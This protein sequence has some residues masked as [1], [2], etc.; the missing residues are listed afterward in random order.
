MKTFFDFLKRRKENL[1]HGLLT[2]P[3]AYQDQLTSNFQ[4]ISE[5][6]LQME[7]R[8]DALNQRIIDID[9]H[10]A[11]FSDNILIPKNNLSEFSSTYSYASLGY[12]C[13]AA[14]QFRRISGIDRASFFNWTYCNHTAMMN[15]IENEFK[16]LLMWENLLPTGIMV[17]DK[18]HNLS[19]HGSVFYASNKGNYVDLAKIHLALLQSKTIHLIEKWNKVVN[20]PTPVDYFLKMPKSSNTRDITCAVR[21]LLKYKYPRHQFRIIVLQSLE[22]VTAQPDWNEANIHNRYLDRFATDEQPDAADTDSWDRLFAEF[23]LSG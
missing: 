14:Y 16:D 11:H 23:P 7:H 6:I 15:L 5:R 10:I 18:R 3:V 19:F 12:N 2:T 22:D 21:D 4:I 17:Y 8:L 13:E 9:H 20:L 1:E